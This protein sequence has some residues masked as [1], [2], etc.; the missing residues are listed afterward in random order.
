MSETAGAPP[1]LIDWRRPLDLSP[2]VVSYFVLLPEAVPFPPSS[3]MS[4]Q[5][6]TEALTGPL[7]DVA[8]PDG[9]G[10]KLGRGMTFAWL[11]YLQVP[12]P[13]GVDYGAL[14]VLHEAL[15]EVVPPGLLPTR[16][17][18]AKLARGPDPQ[19]ADG[20]ATVVEMR[21]GVVVPTQR[22]I[23][24]GFELCFDL[25]V[26]ADRTLRVSQRR[27]S[28]RLTLPRVHQLAVVVLGRLDGRWDAP[29]FIM[30]T[31]HDLPQAEAPA[32]LDD[33][34][35]AQYHLHQ[36]A[37]RSGHPMILYWDRRLQGMGAFDK[38][39]YEEA[40]LWSA[41]AAEVMLDALL[42]VLLWEEGAPANQVVQT[43]RRTLARRVDHEY[44]ERLGTPPWRRR[45]ASPVGR[46]YLRLAASRNSIVHRGHAPHRAETV[47]AIGAGEDLADYLFGCVIAR[48]EARPFTANIIAGDPIG[49]SERVLVPLESLPV[50]R[51]LRWCG[52]LDETVGPSG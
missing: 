15:R 28:V 33:D 18:T 21:T 13:A 7:A 47:E 45:D 10:M 35:L 2:R 4:M 5:I 25:A 1:C 16:E 52:E 20:M 44:H 42:M 38:G 17:A 49:L 8:L 24:E 11:R 31:H 36:Q 41:V 43:F 50:E 9:S 22:A 3:V 19:P 6:Q 37:L 29:L 34:A 30:A 32:F 23:E 40:I 26:E 51:F 12:R 39:D 48:R 46:W 27:A 14:H